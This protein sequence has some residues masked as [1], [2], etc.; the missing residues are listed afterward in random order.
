MTVVD[1]SKV[2]SEFLE[3][4]LANRQKAQDKALYKDWYFCFRHEGEGEDWFH[5]M[6]K[7]FW[8]RHHR[9]DDHHISGRY[10]NL[11]VGFSE[12]TTSTFMYSGT[13]DEGIAL[14]EES[15]FVRIASDQLFFGSVGE[16][17]KIGDQ[18]VR[19][20]IVCD[21]PAM[22]QVFEVTH[23][24]GDG[25]STLDGYRVWI[26]S[27]VPDT[28]FEILYGS[29]QFVSAC[30]MKRDVAASLPAYPEGMRD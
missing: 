5:L 3:Q 29:G 19:M 9:V 12:E 23:R 25:F 14:L 22:K 4:E 26:E 16:I 7:R 24:L 2:S 15:G 11:P 21:E 30:W 28:V 20:D 27:L 18:D 13:V 1:L 6:H 8:H 10:L 17:C